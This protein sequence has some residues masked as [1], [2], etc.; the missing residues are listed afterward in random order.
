MT[1]VELALKVMFA[2]LD[3]IV[4]TFFIRTVFYF[5][6]VKRDKIRSDQFAY[7]D[8]DLNTVQ[9]VIF[10]L[11]FTLAIIHFLQALLD[12]NYPLFI[13]VAGQNTEGNT[14]V[15]WMSEYVGFIVMNVLDFI[16]GIGFLYLFDKMGM[17]QIRDEAMKSGTM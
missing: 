11:I 8:A 15:N 14:T 16:S 6:K 5:R 9:K 7:P 17:K 1:K 3:L 12:V 2:V 13:L 10:A 4:V